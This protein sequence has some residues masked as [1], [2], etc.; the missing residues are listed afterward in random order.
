[1]CCVNTYNCTNTRFYTKTGVNLH[2]FAVY[3]TFFHYSY[4]ELDEEDCQ[5]VEQ[6]VFCSQRQVAHEAGSFLND[7]LLSEAE[8]SSPSKKKGTCI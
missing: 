7:R 2:I 4:G 8:R 3:Y 1:M 5:Q 6:L